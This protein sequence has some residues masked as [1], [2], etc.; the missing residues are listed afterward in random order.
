MGRGLRNDGMSHQSMMGLEENAVNLNVFLV[1][2][3][4]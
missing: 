4:K 2:G 1:K 3:K